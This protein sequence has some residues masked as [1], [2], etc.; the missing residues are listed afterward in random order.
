[1][2]QENVEVVRQMLDSFNRADVGAVIG[3]FDKNCKLH[4]PPEMPDRLALG[5][6]G[7]NGIRDWMANLRDVGGIEFEPISF[8]TRGDVIFSE[9][10]AR[11]RGQASGVP[12]EWRTFAVV[13]VRDAKIVRVE[14]FLGRDEALDTARLSE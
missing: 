1:M 8:T 2:S 5:F 7:H 4:E 6:R 10:I 14:S 12:F 9:L 13:Q 3:T 11:G